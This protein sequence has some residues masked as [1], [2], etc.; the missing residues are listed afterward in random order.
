MSRPFRV[1]VTDLHRHCQ[2]LIRCLA[3]TPVNPVDFKFLDEQILGVADNNS[4]RL[5][6]NIDDVTRSRRTAGQTFAL[7]N[8]EHLD[9]LMLSDAVAGLVVNAAG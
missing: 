7:P 1:A 4:A 3:A 5:R 6:I 2:P 9:A 8:S